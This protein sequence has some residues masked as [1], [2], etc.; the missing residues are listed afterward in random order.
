MSGVRVLRKNRSF[1]L[2]PTAPFHFDGTFHKS[3]HFPAGMDDWQPGIYWQSIR[4]GSKLIG[5]RIEDCGRRRSPKLK[6]T[7]FCNRG[8]DDGEIRRLGQELRW[9]FDL[10]ADLREFNRRAARD[11]RFGP[12]FRKWLGMRVSNAYDLYGLLVVGVVLQN[13][14]VRR[15]VQMMESLLET[16]GI[17]LRFDGKE[18]FAMWLPADLEPVSE[19][20]LRALR[21]GYR[22]KSLKR[23]S[24]DFADG[25]VNERVL[26]SMGKQDARDE[27]MKLYGVGPETARI[28]MH[29][30]FHDY[31]AFD[32][33]APWQQKIYSRL[34]YN[35]ATV[36]AKRIRDD[37]RAQYGE[38]AMLAVHY[39]WEDLFW[40]R[41]TERIPWLE[42]EIRL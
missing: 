26:R 7:T 2:I 18:L 38:Y 28:V 13:A 33:V 31:G 36:S 30:A 1:V 29:D 39:V 35:R 27:L 11:R 19:Q 21:I 17:R 10:D 32:H 4:I 6:V 15:T 34:F 12:V 24:T 8:L 42:K 9:R 20:Q 14:T 22:A 16:F 5:L 23:L 40:K 41:R 37:I 3:S 25:K